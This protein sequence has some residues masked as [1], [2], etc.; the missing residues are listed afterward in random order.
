MVGQRSGKGRAKVGQRSGRGRAEVGQG[1]G[2]GRAKVGQRSGRGRAR[3]SKFNRALSMNPSGSNVVNGHL[4]DYLMYSYS[5]FRVT[6]TMGTV[7]G[8]SM[9]KLNHFFLSQ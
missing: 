6:K 7:R 4:L 3:N 5:T 1:S 9:K 2:K 8:G